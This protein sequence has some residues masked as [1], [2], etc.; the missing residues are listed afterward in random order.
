MYRVFVIT[1]Y[2]D[3]QKHNYFTNYHN[4]LYFYTIVSFSVKL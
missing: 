4:P 3:Q 2:Y 1:L